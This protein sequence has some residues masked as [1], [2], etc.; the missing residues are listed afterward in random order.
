MTE[1]TSGVHFPDVTS[2]SLSPSES[3]K[4][5]NGKF[6]CGNFSIWW[7][8]I[9]GFYRTVR[10]TKTVQSV[11]RRTSGIKSV[12]SNVTMRHIMIQP[13]RIHTVIFS[14]PRRAPRTRD[15]KIECTDSKSL[16]NWLHVW[17]FPCKKKSRSPETQISKT[18]EYF[19]E[20]NVDF[21]REFPFLWFQKFADPWNLSLGMSRLFFAWIF[22][23]SWLGLNR[24]SN[25]PLRIRISRAACSSQNVSVFAIWT[26]K[27]RLAESGGAEQSIPGR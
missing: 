5:C 14:N 27:R 26:Q 13:S 21:P 17:Y 11:T 10:F 8:P 2:E 1:T 16:E 4:I 9:Y 18:C 24:F 12:N 23:S 3:I 7:N 19:C 20:T 6:W 25:L 22:M 15:L